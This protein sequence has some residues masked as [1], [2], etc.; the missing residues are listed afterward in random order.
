[1]HN[2]FKTHIRFAI[3][4]IL[5]AFCLASVLPFGCGFFGEA[6]NKVVIVVGSKDITTEELKYDMDFMSRGLGKHLMQQPRIRNQLV[7][8]IIDHYL[9]L[10]YSAERGI[11]LSNEEFN[12]ELRDIREGYSA[13]AFGETLLKVYVDPE[14][15]MNRLKELLLIKKAIKKATK[16]IDPPT[17]EEIKQYFVMNQDEFRSPNLLKFRQ[18][19]AKSKEEAENLLKRLHQGEDMGELA[20]RYSIAPEAE[21]GGEVG[22]V[23]RGLLEESMDKPLFSMAV[24]KVSPVIK[25]S[26]G[27]HIFEVLSTRPEGIKSLFGVIAEIES[28]LSTQKHA[29]FCK[30]WLKT[31]RAHFEVEIDWELLNRLEFS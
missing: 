12:S 2:E 25:T 27:Y 7:E 15:W 13:K 30:E 5:Y 6:E 23:A 9:V 24:G 16:D 4:C 31:L 10:E 14:Q 21:N 18:I 28:K 11:T 8:R 17:Y 1:M 22:W 19:V 26:Y 29:V 20:I 3:N